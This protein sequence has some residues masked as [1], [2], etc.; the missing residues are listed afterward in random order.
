M[1]RTLTMVLGCAFPQEHGFG[2]LAQRRCERRSDRDYQ[3]KNKFDVAYSDYFGHYNK[4]PTPFS[5]IP[6][7]GRL[8]SEPQTAVMH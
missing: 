1:K 2:R 5:A 6:E 4:A 8:Q 3:A 7:S